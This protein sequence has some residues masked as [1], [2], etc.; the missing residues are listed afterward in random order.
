MKSHT[1]S[2]TKT[3]TNN[4]GPLKDGLRQYL[5]NC[6]WYYKARAGGRTIS[7][8]TGTTEKREA[9]NILLNKKAEAQLEAPKQKAIH[10]TLGQVRALW[11]EQ[12]LLRVRA[13]ALS[14]KTR[15]K[16]IWVWTSISKLWKGVEEIPAS[17]L[18]GKDLLTWQ[19]KFRGEWSADYCNKAV[20]VWR[21]FFEIAVTEKFTLVD[22]T[23]GLVWSFVKPAHYELPSA[24]QVEAILA[25]IKANRLNRFRDQVHDLVR[26]LSV[27]GLRIEES[28]LLLVSHVEEVP[29]TGLLRLRLPSHICKGRKHGRIVHLSSAATEHFRKLC[30]GKAPGAAVFDAKQAD[31]SLTNA[32]E[33]IGIDRITHH[34]LRHI[35]AT[36]CLEQKVPVHIVAGW[37]GH[38]DNGAL[39]L[40]TYAHLVSS[41]AEFE[42]QA[43]D[44]PVRVNPIGHEII[45]PTAADHRTAT[46]VSAIQTSE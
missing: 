5:P 24:D 28:N 21:E 4:W 36:R 19:A 14:D 18:T 31:E 3:T 35:F 2:T 10:G 33:A 15:Q 16:R 13:G 23:K 41:A 42:A 29:A 34:T 40:K 26:G 25:H 7:G 44:K 11:E 46:A 1:L 43:L 32:C 12:L 20:G 8:C 37:L 6:I 27:S 30:E 22:P 39:L 45:T 9:R 17:R 38:V